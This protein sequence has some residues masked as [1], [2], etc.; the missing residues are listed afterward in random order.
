M[1]RASRFL[2]VW[3]PCVH[4]LLT[5]FLCFQLYLFAKSLQ[6]EVLTLKGKV[7]EFESNV[8]IIM[9]SINKIGN[10]FENDA[11]LIHR[12]LGLLKTELVQVNSNLSR[13]IPLIKN[14]TKS[15][16]IERSPVVSIN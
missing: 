5:L 10:L 2:F 13:I 7:D 3:T 8:G 1:N 16:N 4:F 6:F 11:I 9:D 12:E 14:L 15:L